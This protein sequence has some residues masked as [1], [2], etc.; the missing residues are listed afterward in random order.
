MEDVILEVEK[1]V[2]TGTAKVARLRK[3]ALFPAVVYG[4]GKDPL[5]VQVAAKDFLRLIGIHKGESFVINLKVKDGARS[6]NKSV[7]IKQIQHDPVSD[8]IIHVDFHEISLTKTI[9]V[10]VP[11]TAKGDALGVKRDGGVLDHTMWDL[12]IEC[13]P[14]Q[15][16]ESVEVDVSDLK[17]GDSLH[18]KDIRLPQGVKVLNDPESVVLAVVT[19]TKEVPA[20]GEEAAAGEA[21]AEP[22]VIKE[23]KEKPEGASEAGGKKEEKK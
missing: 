21:K 8:G 10:K 4:E 13:L 9:R 5:S 6:E 11:L 14:T 15:I 19:P 2:D 1:R 22:E 12:E 3:K 18:I 7:L 16:P 20:A 17:I 23:K